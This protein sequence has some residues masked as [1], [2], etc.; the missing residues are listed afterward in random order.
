M[1]KREIVRCLEAPRPG[2]VPEDVGDFLRALAGPTWIQIAGRDRS[3][4]RAVSTLLHGN[5]P[6]GL[7][8]V[9]SWLRAGS[10]PAVDTVVFIGAVEAAL[11]SPGFGHRALPGRRDLNRC[12]HP[13]W[14]GDEGRLAQRALELL[15]KVAPEALI[16]IHNTTGHSPSYGVAPRNG[17][18]ERALTSLFAKRLVHNSLSLRAIVEATCDDFPSVTIECGRAGDPVAD[19]IARA[20]LERFLGADQVDGERAPLD[21][22]VD[23]VRVGVRAGAVVAF[24]PERN[25][26]ADLTVA[27]DVDRH[28]FETLAPGTEIGWTGEGPSWPL[29]AHGA[30]GEEVSRELFSLGDGV[31]RTRRD[32][33]PIMMTVDPAIAASDCL[34]YAV[35]R[36]EANPPD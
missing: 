19:A 31:I 24:G 21:L 4:T 20:G 16:D 23:P 28:N 6:S 36:A 14:D 29:E 18:A 9:H 10:T 3:R 5:E 26:A 1:A 17:A 11:E 13:P 27:E 22:L 30:D 34:F 7:R 12:F 33:I 25:S 2:D 32:L 35:R 15:H 8:A